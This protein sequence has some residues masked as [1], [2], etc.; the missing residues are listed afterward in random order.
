MGQHKRLKWEDL[1]E[2]QFVGKAEDDCE[3]DEEPMRMLDDVERRNLLNGFRVYLGMLSE[4]E[5]Y[6]LD[7]AL[8]GRELKD[9]L[10][11][12]PQQIT[13]EGMEVV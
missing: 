8:E 9:F 2:E 5:L 1:N 7:R 10:E 13:I 4:R 6:F 11:I 12:D 3:A